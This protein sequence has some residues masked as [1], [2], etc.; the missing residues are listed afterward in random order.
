[1][2]TIIHRLDKQQG[3]TASAGNSIQ[4]PGIKHNGKEFLGEERERDGNDGSAEGP[5]WLE[6][7]CLR[8]FPCESLNLW[9]ATRNARATASRPR[10][11]T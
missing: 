8:T 5:G 2:Q 6:F 1:M 7:M 9:R 3:P 10:P 4:Y 11:Q